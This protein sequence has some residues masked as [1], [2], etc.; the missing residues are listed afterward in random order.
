MPS[1]KGLN[2]PNC[3]A[4]LQIRGYEHTLSVV[5][6]NCLSVLD[7]KDPSH[8]VLQSFRE[9]ERVL[10]LIP[11]GA[12][13]KLHGDPYEVIGFQERTIEVEGIPYSWHEYLLFNPFKGFRYLTHYNGHWNDV[14]TVK[15]VPELTN[16]KGRPAMRLLGETYVHFQTAKAQ[17]TFVM[18][19]FPWQARVGEKAIVQDFIAPPRMLSAEIT[20]NEKTWSL[21][22]YMTGARVWEAFGLPGSSPPAVGTFANQPSPYEGKVRS[23]W[24]TCLALLLVLA[25]F[26]ALCAV[27]LR[28]E[29]VFRRSYTFS[30]GRPGE[31]SFV[32]PVFELKGRR[33]NVELSIRT[34]LSNNWAYF[35]FA[36]INEQTGQAY[37]FGREVSYY[38]G[39]DSD[40]D[41]AEGGPGDR[42]L[43]PTVP[44]GRYYLRVEPEMDPANIDRRRTVAM[45]YEL[46]LRRDVPAYGY[47]W[48]A[49]LLLLIPPAVTTLRAAGFERARW[50]ESD[51]APADSPGSDYDN[52]DD[53]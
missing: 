42:V 25:G 3:G 22:E 47:F 53:D 18:G 37:D 16:R 15:G 8:R 40:G 49:G 38:F 2:C 44:P 14:K 10:P 32:T 9:R 51:Y 11:L 26:A 43:I 1:V 4:A 19:E 46:R 52:G 12:R 24:R 20:D 34:D 5:C 45:S 7:A 35:N 29:E 13:G 31:A 36:L 28:Q 33:S 27:L 30:P 50:A 48:I 6:I 23:M 17:T 41:W 21:G 39:R